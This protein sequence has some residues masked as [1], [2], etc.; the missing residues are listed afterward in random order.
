MYL[1]GADQMIDDDDE[2]KAFKNGI[3]CVLN[4]LD[5]MAEDDWEK[6]PLTDWFNSLPSVE[7]LNDKPVKTLA[8]RGWEYAQMLADKAKEEKTNGDNFNYRVEVWKGAWED[9]EEP[10]P[11]NI[12]YSSGYRLHE[13]DNDEKG[14]PGIC[15]TASFRTPSGKPYFV[16]FIIPKDEL[17]K[18][19]A[20]TVEGSKCAE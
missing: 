3:Q 9:K 6:D 13:W 17:I 5:M 11:L 7:D 12:D 16:Q 14:G 8:E 20:L 1:S 2:R 19:L 4:E 18:A 15:L 10:T